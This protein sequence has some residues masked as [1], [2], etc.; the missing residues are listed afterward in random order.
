MKNLGVRR[1]YYSSGF[2]NEIKFEVVENMVSIQDS[3]SSKRFCRI[4]Y[5]YPVDDID[6]YKLLMNMHLPNVIKKENLENF[7]KYYLKE[8]ITTLSFELKY[9]FEKNGSD[10][11]FKIFANNLSLFTMKVL[12]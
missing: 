12:F 7:I 11:Y 1:V 3:S 8:S 10:T 4:K 9:I 5:N 6:Y 2:G